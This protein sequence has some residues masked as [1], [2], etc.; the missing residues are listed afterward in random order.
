MENATKALIIAAAILIAIVLISLGVFV[1]GQGTTMVKENSDMSDVEITTYNSKF[2]A[3][4]GDNVS[5]TKVKQLINAV[6]QNNKSTNDDSRQITLT[7]GVESGATG[8]A[9]V[10]GGDNKNYPASQIK[11]GQSYVVKANSNDAS[12]KG[13]YTSGGL[14]KSITINA[15]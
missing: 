11:S 3:F 14:I 7:G 10:L 6:N 13:G 9:P 4:F 8:A 15:K 5:G 12:T 1:L 2:E